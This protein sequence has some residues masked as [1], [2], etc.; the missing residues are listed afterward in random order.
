M[1]RVL[2]LLEDDPREDH[3]RI[4]KLLQLQ[5]VDSQNYL[6]VDK[7]RSWLQSLF[8]QALN[9]IADRLEV[10]GVVTLIK[11]RTCGPAHTIYVDGELEYS[12]DFVPAIRLGAE[13][14]VLLADQL[15]YFERANLSF[16]D[17]IPKP[18]KTQTQTSSISFRSSFYLAE[19]AMLMGKHENC[20][21]AIKLMKK[22]R[23]VRTNLSNL[24]SYYI[25][26]LFLWKLSDEPASYWQKPLTSILPEMFDNLVECLRLGTLPFFWDPEL[27]MFDV[28]TRDQLLEMYQCVRKIPSA[29]REAEVRQ[30]H[31]SGLY[32]LRVFSHKQER[33]LHRCSKRISKQTRNGILRLTKE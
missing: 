30:K 22:F 26:T 4:R 2:E 27:N 1:T 25:K 5:L 28:L 7:L 9:R 24:K 21:D 17:A 23:D 3:Q 20:R 13:Q 18:L 19:R 8:S 15:I 33:S 11:Y 6:V 14:N 12:V 31:Y 16:W 32:V 29:L 10:D